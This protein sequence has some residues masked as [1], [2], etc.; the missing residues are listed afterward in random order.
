M[1]NRFSMA[2]HVPA[3][4]LAILAMLAGARSAAAQ[5]QGSWEFSAG[6]GVMSIDRA[7]GGFLVNEGF[8]NSA[9]PGRIAPAAGGRI[10]YNFNRHLGLSLGA[11]T[12]AGSGMRYTA[13][14]LAATYTMNLNAATS[15]FLTVGT[16]FTRITGNGF[17][18]HPTWGTHVG[19]GVRR[20]VSER[21][22]LR[23]EGRISPEHYAE[24]PEAKSAFNGVLML[25][26]S[27]FTSGRRPRTVSMV[28]ATCPACARPQ[29]ARVDTVRS[30]RVDTLRTTRTDTVRVTEVVSADQV[31]LR[32]QF[33]TER[34]ELLPISRPILNTV[35]AAIKATPNSRWQVE[36][37]TDSV[38]TNARNQ[39]LSQARAQTVVDYLV[40]QGVN[41]SDLTAIG[42]GSDR[43]VFSNTTAAGRAQNRRVQLRRIP[44]APATVIP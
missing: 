44:A 41:R 34:A 18:V 5:R 23:L 32:V 30:V 36:G 27:Y 24:L 43:Q 22:A 7:L 3:A 20:M 42:F 10:G 14:F 19:I 13:P 15:P 21:L 40:T 39:V 33:R 11:V 25:G 38:G 4:S 28:P 1:R 6:A 16:Q 29:M 8:S 35:A 26:V 9:S 12:A 2:R 37:H 31:I 17:K